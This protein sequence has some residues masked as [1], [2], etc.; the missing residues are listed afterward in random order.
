ME[1]WAWFALVLLPFHHRYPYYSDLSTPSSLFHPFSLFF[2]SRSR[3]AQF[4]FLQPTLFCFLSGLGIGQ[5]VQRFSIRGQWS[6]WGSSS[7]AFLLLSAH[8]HRTVSL[9]RYLH[10]PL[11]FSHFISPIFAAIPD[12]R[13][14][15]LS[16]PLN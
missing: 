12:S 8:S 5:M 9:V 2:C 14:I 13:H 10:G 4:Q 7:C 15:S 1:A 6:I 11:N 16:F 3:L